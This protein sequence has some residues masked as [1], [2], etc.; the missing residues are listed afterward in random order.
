MPTDNEL[1]L[2]YDRTQADVARIKNLNAKGWANMTADEKAYYLSGVVKGAYNAAD[3]NRVST[4]QA[5]LKEY[6]DALPP[7]LG[8]YRAAAI[9][10][11]IATLEYDDRYYDFDGDVLPEELE[12]VSYKYPVEIET[13]KTDW[14]ANDYPG[15][16]TDEDNNI[17][18][19]GYYLTNVDILREVL[20]ITAPETPTSLENLT[21]VKAND[22][23]KILTEIY[24]A[25]TAYKAEKRATIDEA[26]EAKIKEQQARGCSWIWANEA[27][28][29]EF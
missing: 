8:E 17:Y 13:V 29:G 1:N 27:Y 24:N 14:T 11:V 7:E 3:I 12:A 22:I 23:E 28:T 26:K 6:F 19:I 16:M 20:Q 10:G 25:Y 4:A 2:I 18:D 21:Y 5:T 9:D 15:T